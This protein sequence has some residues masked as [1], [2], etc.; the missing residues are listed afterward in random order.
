MWLNLD[1]CLQLFSLDL[2][3]CIWIFNN[4]LLLSH[5]KSTDP[6]T[7]DFYNSIQL[8]HY[9]LVCFLAWSAG[10]LVKCAFI[11]RCTF[12]NL[13]CKQQ[14]HNQPTSLYCRKLGTQH[15][16]QRHSLWC[17]NFYSNH[18]S[19]KSENKK[20]TFLSDPRTK[21]NLRSIRN[22]FWSNLIHNVTNLSNNPHQSASLQVDAWF[23][24]GAGAL[25]HFPSSSR[26]IGSSS[27]LL[28]L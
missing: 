9:V 6:S 5:S 26:K 2:F 13:H 21:G 11:P 28:F 18:N 23:W 27:R 19:K 3:C 22:L 7:D 4:L 16:Q 10:K 25:Q 12:K 24:F 20:P 17:A 15:T 14:K 8:V 1:K